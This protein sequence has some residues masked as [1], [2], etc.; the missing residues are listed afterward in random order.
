VFWH[1]VDACKG[2]HR[3]SQSG[4]AAKFLLLAMTFVVAVTVIAAAGASPLVRPIPDA[5][6]RFLGCYSTNGGSLR[7]VTRGPCPRGERLVVWSQRGKTGARGQAGEVGPA[8]P[9]GPVGARGD[10]GP[11]GPP[12]AQGGQGPIGAAG[13]AG[14]QGGPGAQGIQGDPGP[15]GPPGATGPAG[16]AGATGATGPQGPAGP[17]G[18]QGP[19]GPTGPQG[20]AGPAGSTRVLGTPVTSAVNAARHTLVTATAT[21][22]SGVLLGGGGQVT[23]TSANKD[24]AVL[25]ASYPSST[26]VWTATAVVATAALGAGQTMTV[27]AYALCSL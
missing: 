2:A 24:R 23:T 20:P 7:L 16:P 8:G 27:Q 9:S 19:A 4:I 22:P 25:V 5:K 6:G 12:G 18:P 15:Q 21:C 1:I 17:T 11:P 26:T 14:I 3:L 13:P 10:A